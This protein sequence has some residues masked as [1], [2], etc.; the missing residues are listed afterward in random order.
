M[1]ALVFLAGCLGN[2]PG[3]V[4][5][6]TKPIDKPELVLPQSDELQLKAVKWQV[7]TPENIDEVFVEITESGRPATMFALT[8]QGYEDLGLNLS[9]LR[10][11]IQQQQVI[12]AAYENYYQ[13]AEETMDNAVVLN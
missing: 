10:T 13:K 1:I 3:P 7:V 12:I 2:N 11:Y 4:E 5:I 8:D 9:D 6:T